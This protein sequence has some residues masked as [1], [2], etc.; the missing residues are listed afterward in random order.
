MKRSFGPP[1]R[2]RSVVESL[3]RRTLLSVGSLDPSFGSLG[4]LTADFGGS[5]GDFSGDSA[6]AVLV[7]PG[8][9]VLLIGTGG[10]P[11]TSD[12]AL[13]RFN[14]DGSPDLSFGANHSGRVTTDFGG[15]NGDFATAATLQPDGKILVAGIRVSTGRGGGGDGEFTGPV[16]FL[17]TF[18]DDVCLARYLPDGS[19]DASFGTGGKAVWVSPTE[20]ESIVHS[21]VTLPGGDIL[22]SFGQDLM[23]FSPAGAL[24]QTVDTGPF[25][26]VALPPA[27]AVLP[28]GKVLVAATKLARLNADLTLDRTFGG[29]DGV[30]PLGFHAGAV[31]AASDGRVTVVGGIDEAPGALVARVARFTPD[32]RAEPGFGGGDGIASADFG[33]TADFASDFAL[34]SDGTTLVTLGEVPFNLY[35]PVPSSF[36]VAR[37]GPDGALDT[38]FGEGGRFVVDRLS[39]PSA[40]NAVALDSAGRAVVAGAALGDF[41]AAR[42]IVSPPAGTRTYEA[43]QARLRGAV[44]SRAHPG[45]TGSGFVD[46]RNPSGDFAEWTV[47]VPSAGVYFVGFRYAN[48]SAT[49]TRPMR[50]TVNG[51]APATVTFPPTGAWKAWAETFAP[52]SL[53]A[54]ASKLRLTATGR[55]GPNVDSISLQPDPRR[56]EAE[57]ATVSGA[58]VSRDHAGYTGAGYVDF[59]HARGDLIEWTIDAPADGFYLLEFDYA[60]GSSRARTMRVTVNDR[61]ADSP[62]A[63]DRTGSWS[64]WSTA[65]I[66]VAMKKGMNRIRLL[67]NGQCG[68]NVDAM[69]VSL[70]DGSTS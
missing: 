33:P 52:V 6:T 57:A 34:L 65:G 35:G 22:L 50:L 53:P 14:A 36:A 18:D 27:L 62:M 16:V 29:G 68:P 38:S 3:E 48:A 70:E 20:P 67:A 69:T 13:A 37:F 45:Y 39:D 58:V 66:H 56:H 41:A 11:E 60:N 47:D 10:T 55:S 51:R 15:E 2:R 49:D 59:Q 25:L 17:T 24:E 23:R 19:P 1:W 61:P 28:G 7:M 63:F 44:V 5:G 32:G 30:A 8:D 46:F 9:K 12:F 40:A 64:T 54:G 4:A 31:G 43:E 26:D 42:I 21:V